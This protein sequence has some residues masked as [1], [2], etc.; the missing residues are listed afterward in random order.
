MDDPLS[1]WMAAA[2]DE[3]NRGAEPEVVGKGRE[4]TIIRIWEFIDHD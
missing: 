4:Q 3:P 2:G 1:D